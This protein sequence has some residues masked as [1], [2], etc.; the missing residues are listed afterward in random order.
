MEIDLAGYEQ[1]GRF[2][3]ALKNGKYHSLTVLDLN[4]LYPIFTGIFETLER[5][6]VVADWKYGLSATFKILNAERSCPF[7]DIAH[8]MDGYERYGIPVAFN[9]MST[10]RDP[11]HPDHFIEFKPKGENGDELFPEIQAAVLMVYLARSLGIPMWEDDTGTDPDLNLLE[12]LHHA[13]VRSMEA[14]SLRSRSR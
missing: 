14:Q 6:A 3:N 8:V 7:L 9:F 5:L 2:V 13:G 11:H 12:E 1:E 4:Q 10:L